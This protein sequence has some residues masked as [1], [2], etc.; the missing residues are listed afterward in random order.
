MSLLRTM[1][2]EFAITR[3]VPCED[4]RSLKAYCD[5]VVGELFLIKG[6]RVIE[7]RGGLFVSMPRQQSQNGKWYDSVV[8]L[9]KEARAELSRAVLEAFRERCATTLMRRDDTMRRM[10]L[11]IM[12][13]LYGM[14]WSATA[15]FAQ[16]P[17]LIRYQG[18]A[19]DSRGVPLEGP[20]TLTFRLYDAPTAGTKVWEEAQTNVSLSG[21]HFS[22]LLGQVTP[23]TS[24]DWSKSC[25]LTIQ[26]GTD[27][28]LAPRQQLTSVPLA[29]R[30]QMAEGL[31]GA[32]VS[33]RA[34]NYLN[35]ALANATS[36]V[37]TFS[38][39]RWDTHELHSTVS[40]TSRLTAKEKGRYLIF[41]HLRFEGWGTG[42]RRL[43]I[44]LNGITNIAQQETNAVSGMPTHVTV[45][46]TYELNPNDY[47]EL[48]AYHNAG[49]G[50]AAE[51]LANSNQS[52]EF[53]MAKVP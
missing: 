13:A 19:V 48:V 44:R 9:P 17:A 18:Q 33:V 45:T 2:M 28:E 22:V 10:L 11:T 32:D 8:L 21:G 27:P 53:G 16:V 26:V 34:Y 42:L 39:E 23:M 14:W 4:G 38:D 37:L 51:T 5:V 47:V 41:G 40:N 31:E 29:M 46:T 36:T 49:T 24:M 12:I 1:G 50:L 30:S 15:A 35:L 25:W 43:T 52:I 3:L 20:Y 6:I 7:G